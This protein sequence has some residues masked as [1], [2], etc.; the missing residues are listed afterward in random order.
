MH[1]T[2]DQHIYIEEVLSEANAYGL[3]AEVQ[4]S[5]NK[6]LEAGDNYE[7][8]YAKAFNEW[9]IQPLLNGVSKL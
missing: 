5:A 9:C 4:K 6:F 7:D 3:K 8:A 1:M 2:L